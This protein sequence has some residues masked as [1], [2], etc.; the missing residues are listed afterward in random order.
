MVDYT[1]IINAVASL[2]D[3]IKESFT[4]LR[5]FLLDVQL[6]SLSLGFIVIFLF[7]IVLVL[8]TLGSPAFL[9]K[10]ITDQQLAFKNFGRKNKNPRDWIGKS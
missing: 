9:Y 3:S 2:K 7:F 1:N 4:V 10:F 6:M 8:I 5:D